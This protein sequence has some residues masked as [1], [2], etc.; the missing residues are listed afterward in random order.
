MLQ[1]H[2]RFPTTE[3]HPEMRIA[4]EG[5]LFQKD[6]PWMVTMMGQSE[7]QLLTFV[8]LFINILILRIFF[9][10]EFCSFLRIILRIRNLYN[11][12][13]FQIST[14]L[15]YL[16]NKWASA[17]FGTVSHADAG[18]NKYINDQVWMLLFCESFQWFNKI[19]RKF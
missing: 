16:K 9:L 12:E 18:R 8:P 7:C 15:S 11:M 1:R 13:C 5:R 4:K 2:I 6:M 3:K 19:L 17:S 14:I 10:L